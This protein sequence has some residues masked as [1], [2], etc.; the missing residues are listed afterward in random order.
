V[1]DVDNTTLP[2]APAPAPEPAPTSSP[3]P[4]VVLRK[5]PNRRAR[6]DLR[7]LL[8]AAVVGAAVLPAAVVAALA[9]PRGDGPRASSSSSSSTSSSGPAALDLAPLR[10][11]IEALPT[12]AP[13]PTTATTTTT[14]GAAAPASL[15]VFDTKRTDQARLLYRKIAKARDA[16]R[17]AGATGADLRKPFTVDELGGAAALKDIG[18]VAGKRLLVS[19]D[20]KLVAP[21]GAALPDVGVPLA[22]T[23]KDEDVLERD[24]SLD[25]KPVHVLRRCV[26]GELLCLVD[27]EPRGAAVPPAAAPS[28]AP[29]RSDELAAAKARLLALVDALPTVGPAPSSAAPADAPADAP[30][31][32]RALALLAGLVV[33]LALSLPLALSLR[34]LGSLLSSSTW[35]LRAGVAGRGLVASVAPTK[36]AEIAELERAIDE[37]LIAVGDAFAQSRRDEVRRQR[38]H[39]AALALDEARTRIDARLPDPAPDAND[40][41]AASVAEVI[42]SAR[43]LLEAFEARVV[44]WRSHV[45]VV[46]APPAISRVE[47]RAQALAPLAALLVEV[48]ERLLRVARFPDVPEKAQRELTTLAD[49]VASRGK[50]AQTLVD[51]L[52]LDAATNRKGDRPTQALAALRDELAALAPVATSTTT[53]AAL[54]DLG[55]AEIAARMTSSG[56]PS[57]DRDGPHGD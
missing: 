8:P 52:V 34:R 32:S 49:A 24:G 57:L 11:A 7:N 27:V 15:L 36:P 10:A 22:S 21:A 31:T 17:E 18:V 28:P 44:R 19:R 40:A 42:A 16:R 20:G 2:E 25:G 37:A 6:G 30:A 39:A 33:A 46:V 48:S 43:R 26:S 50:T 5:D 38:L 53:V 23:E 14:A 55:P 47:E 29:P 3:A 41:E 1:S 13:A 12:A 56:A 45:D 4:D 35:R 54:A 9:W 51:Q